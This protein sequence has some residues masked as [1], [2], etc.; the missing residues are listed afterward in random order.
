MSIRQIWL[1]LRNLKGS[2][3]VDLEWIKLN[4]SISIVE[5]PMRLHY[6]KSEMQ[7]EN[8]KLMLLSKK[9]SK[10]IGLYFITYAFI[11]I[12]LTQY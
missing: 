6:Q 8:C 3:M 2:C 7:E 10:R 5:I 12:V 9:K 4:E 11:R 1:N